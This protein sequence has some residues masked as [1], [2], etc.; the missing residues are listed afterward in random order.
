MKSPTPTK[1]PIYILG[2]QRS[3][4]S[5]LRRII[6]SHSNIAAPAESAFLVQLARMFEIKRSLQGLLDMGFS[7]EDVLAQMR[8]FICHFF[9][10]DTKS[11]G[12]NRWA[13]KTTPYLDHADTIERIFNG[14]VV[15]VGIVRH[16]LDVANSLSKMD[17][18]VL[19]PYFAGDIDKRIAG[20]KFWRD[21]NQK[22]LDFKSKV[23]DRFH[24]IRYEELTESPSPVLQDLFSFLYEPWESGVLNYNNYDHDPGFESDEVA[25]HKSIVPNSGRYKAWPKGL[26]EQAFSEAREIFDSLDYHLN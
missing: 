22:L 2:C 1:K 10:E 13:D 6:G 21:Q 26:Q 11:K 20:I 8:V 16:G 25:E 24:L 14:E 7:E 9:D 3:G 5:L 18:G 17:W 4:T 19:A 12:K 23:G 15:Y